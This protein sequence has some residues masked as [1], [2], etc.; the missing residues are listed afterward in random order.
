MPI[1]SSGRPSSSR[2][3]R[4]AGWP[5]LLALAKRLRAEA[6]GF[7]LRFLG[8]FVAA[9]LLWSFVAPAYATALAGAGGLVASIIDPGS[10]YQSDGPKVSAVRPLGT[11][12]DG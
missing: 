9:A 12:L 7:A 5:G 1:S 4:R 11:E 8:A 2:P 10:R 3:S 6:A